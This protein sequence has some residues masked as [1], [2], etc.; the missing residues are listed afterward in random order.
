[1]IHVNG[2]NKD[3]MNLGQK[4]WKRAKKVIPGGSMLL[5]KNPDLH[6][7]KFWP[8]Y[9]SKAVG[10]NIWDLENKIFKDIFLMGVGTNI[11][12]YS[13]YPIE[14]T[15]K[16][17]LFK[18][19]MTSLN[20]VDE[21]LLAE[22]LISMHKWAEKVRF[23]R[24]GG[25]A[26]A[27]AIRIARAYVN[28]SNI[29]VCGY[30]GWHDWYLSANLTNK[31][32]LDKHLFKNLKINGIP[33]ELKN[34]VY[35]FEYNNYNQLKNLV[36]KKNIGVVKMEVERNEKPKDNFLIKIR[37]LCNKKKIVLIFDECTSGFR[38]CF[39]GLHLNY[40]INPDILILGKALGN[41]YAINSILG[42]K[43]IMDALNKT[44]ISSTFWT[45]RLGSIAALE[46]LKQME[47]I[48]SWKIISKIGKKIKKNWSMIAKNNKLDLTIQGLNAL[49]NFIFNSNNHNL[50]KT[51]ISQEML[52]KKFLASNVIYTSISHNEKF[53]RD[54]FDLLNDIFVN[55]S[56]CENGTLNIKKLLE[57]VPAIN[58][59]RSR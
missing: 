18:S 51:Y 42:K 57:T 32:N 20:S 59:M 47:K 36:E 11:L 25:E 30:H 58:G 49:P 44:F 37:K 1:L 46:T 5:S 34:T 33:K 16:K 22:K 12:G 35:A 19:N 56:K 8:A 17:N 15:I 10:S 43:D 40:K 29:S 31:N 2:N 23:T 55:I 24:S 45:E 6:L 41:G 14:N 4:Y 13:Y 52:K 54:Y 50:Y 21:I 53:L 9:Y 28:K 39:G 48:K 27:V 3:I 7:P 38:S 26:N